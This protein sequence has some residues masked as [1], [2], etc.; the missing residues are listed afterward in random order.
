MATIAELA[1]VHYPE[2]IQG[3]EADE[4]P[5]SDRES[6]S[7]RAQIAMASSSPKYKASTAANEVAFY[8]VHASDKGFQWVWVDRAMD[9]TLY[10]DTSGGTFA[11]RPEALRDAAEDWDYHG[12]GGTLAR[13]LRAAATR[14]EKSG[15][16][17]YR[18]T[19]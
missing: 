12:G 5:V 2:D 19:I 7:A 16:Q 13:T 9:G 6:Q 17:R 18:W 15:E 3:L 4:G 14:V 8:S 1:Q 10:F 11:T